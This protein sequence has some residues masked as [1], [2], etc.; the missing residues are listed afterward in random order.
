LAG[1]T[2]QRGRSKLT[3][4]VVPPDL[5]AWL[6]HSLSSHISLCNVCVLLNFQNPGM[7]LRGVSAG[8]K[9]K[10]VFAS[11]FETCCDPLVQTA[12]MAEP[13]TTLFPEMGRELN[14]VVQ[15]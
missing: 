10:E 11:F 14:H 4:L 3:T 1:T 13:R 2:I 15:L 9:K 7:K 8:T 5:A 6:M 12:N